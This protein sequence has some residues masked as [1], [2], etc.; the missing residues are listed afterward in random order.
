MRWRDW[1]QKAEGIQE[2]GRQEARFAFFPTLSFA[3]VVRSDEAD[4]YLTFLEMLWNSFI[5]NCIC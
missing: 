4:A 3:H 2:H 1:K 5:G